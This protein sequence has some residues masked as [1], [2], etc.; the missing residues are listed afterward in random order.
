MC[1]FN[2]RTQC[3]TRSEHSQLWLY[4]TSL[5]MCK[6]KVAVGCEII[7]KTQTQCEHHVE[8]LNVKPD[9]T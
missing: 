4:K 9:G 6:A 3:A 5:L 2:I 8:Y 7:Q 1:I